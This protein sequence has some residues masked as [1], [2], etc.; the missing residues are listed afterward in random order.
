MKKQYK[1]TSG[2]VLSVFFFVCAIF[3]TYY[4]GNENGTKIRVAATDAHPTV[5]V[6]SRTLEDR[7][8]LSGWSAF[9][10]RVSAVVT[11]AQKNFH[12]GV[13][14][15]SHEQSV[16]GMLRTLGEHGHTEVSITIPEGSDLRDIAVKLQKEGFITSADALYAITGYPAK[17]GTEQQ[18]IPTSS[19]LSP[20]LK[21]HISLEGF[22]FPD[23]YRF[24]TDA[25]PVDI[26]QK[27]T[28]NF[29][30]RTEDARAGVHTENFH[31]VLTVASILE[32]EVRSDKDRQMVSDILW[33]RLQLGMPLQMDSTVHYATGKTTLFTTSEDRKTQS[34]WNTYLNKGLPLGPINNPGMS[35][36]N[37]ALHPQANQYLYFLTGKDGAVHYAKTLDE[38]IANKKYL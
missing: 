16:H 11:G 3:F 19:T 25:T 34:P 31:A 4:S 13:F 38:Q 2:L 24:Y 10:F 18:V 26:V 14:A 23:T 30:T 8:V 36:I 6:M 37:A 20:Y 28:D 5:D 22:L 15:L 7:G 1:V 9:V 33:R 32:A 12:E 35:A 17:T 27:M 29:L 21:P